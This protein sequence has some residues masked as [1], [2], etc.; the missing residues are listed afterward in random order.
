ML[1]FAHG[2][3][4][5]VSSEFQPYFDREIARLRK[6]LD[7]DGLRDFKSSDG[8]L[9]PNASFSAERLHHLRGVKPKYSKLSG[10]IFTAVVNSRHGA[11]LLKCGPPPTWP[12]FMRQF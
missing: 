11:R 12:G 6:E 3:L 4:L 2:E 10:P 7:S 9:S 5:D 1:R 8:N